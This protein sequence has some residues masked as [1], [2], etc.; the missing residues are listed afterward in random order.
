MSLVTDITEE[1]L[2]A[3]QAEMQSPL[4][5]E[6]LTKKFTE[7]VQPAC[8]VNLAK[9]RCCSKHDPASE[10]EITVPSDGLHPTRQERYTVTHWNAE[11][12]STP[13]VFEVQ[14]DEGGRIGPIY[15]RDPNRYAEAHKA[16]PPPGERP[17]PLSDSD[18]ILRMGDGSLVHQ[19]K[20]CF[21]TSTRRLV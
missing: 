20:G 2:A 6:R 19:T 4:H 18:M 7:A 21:G 12:F 13:G 16:Q 14:V 5:V 15:N 10:T 11:V 17:V 3:L 9:Q 8:L 1:E